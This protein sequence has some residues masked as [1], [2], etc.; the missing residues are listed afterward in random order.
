M[1]TEGGSSNS[2][3]GTCHG[4]SQIPAR[5]ERGGD[6]DTRLGYAQASE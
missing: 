5:G 3:D 2:L 1:A 6:S 4:V